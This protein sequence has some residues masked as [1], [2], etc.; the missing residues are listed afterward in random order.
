LLLA[1]EIHATHQKLFYRAD[2]CTN[3]LQKPVNI[4]HSEMVS[5]LMG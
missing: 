3:Q 5:A 1:A 4:Y 2:V